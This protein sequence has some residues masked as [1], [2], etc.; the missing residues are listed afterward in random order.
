MAGPDPDTHWD[1]FQ[2]LGLV[3]YGIE[4]APG[5]ETDSFGL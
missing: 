4:A 5:F 1:P 3:P 2:N